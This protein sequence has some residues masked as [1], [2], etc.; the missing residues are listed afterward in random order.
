MR[1]GS[2]LAMATEKPLFVLVH[3]PVVGPS[4]W[5]WVARELEGRDRSAVVPS[6]FGVADDPNR[7]PRIVREAVDASAQR[8]GTL[9]LVG[10]SGAGSLLPAIAAAC[11]GEVVAIVFVDTFLPPA[12]GRARLVPAEFIEDLSAVASDDVLPP[13]SNWFGEAVMR[14][15]VPDDSRRARVERDMPRLPLSFLRIEVPVPDGW[16]RCPCAYLLLSAE[17]Y[18][19][20]AADARARGWPVAEIEGGKHLD[21]V[22]RPAAVAAAL[23]TLERRM[24]ARP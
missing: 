23:L 8:A 18:A 17:P 24:L 15:L 10:H 2:L 13:W 11:L 12:H 14:D 19:T 21:P 1:C 9:V 22:S 4:T 3:S 20:S 6:L 7:A 16:D 5:A